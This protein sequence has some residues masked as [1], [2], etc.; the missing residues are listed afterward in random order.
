MT[1]VGLTGQ[2]GSGKTTVSAEFAAAGFMVINADILA[3]K[4]MEK[5]QPC[6]EETVRHFGSEILL[7]DGSLDRK[8]LGKIVFSDRKRLD[9]LN[10]ICYKYI[11]RMVENMISDYG[12]Q[13]GEYILLDAPTLFE[14]G[15]DK[16]CDIIVSV[17]ADK[18]LRLKRITE[19][20]KISESAA[21]E[22][23][24]SQNDTEFF[25]S[26]SDYIIENN[27]SFEKLKN[28]AKDIIK[29]IME[30]SNAQKRKE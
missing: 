20:D 24:N 21:E 30:N 13:G 29:Q 15:E 12:R 16:L 6:L 19:R 26:R 11:N 7:P 4:V 14:A 5:G 9:E 8:L 1:V 18:Q 10:G 27:S 3:R 17:T 28:R 2:S 25:R 23:F 22:R